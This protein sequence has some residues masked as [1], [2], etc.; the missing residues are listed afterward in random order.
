MTNTS[1]A[2]TVVKKP[3][4]SWFQFSLRTFL[5]AT[6]IIGGLFTKAS[7]EITNARRKTAAFNRLSSDFFVIQSNSDEGSRRWATALIPKSEWESWFPLGNWEHLSSISF[8]PENFRP[9]PERIERA[10]DVFRSLDAFQSCEEVKM[11]A[12]FGKLTTLYGEDLECFR[13]WRTIKRLK[14]DRCMPTPTALRLLSHSTSLMDVEINGAEIEREALAEFLSKSNLEAFSLQY[15]TL[16]GDT[17]LEI[18]PSL[19]TMDVRYS[20][21]SCDEVS[22]W[23]AQGELE[24][25]TYGPPKAPATRTWN[26]ATLKHR[27]C[28]PSWAS[29]FEL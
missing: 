22:D 1:T 13:G 20:G 2:A 15:A 8:V 27:T 19:R 26:S 7:M 25:L 17:P 10:R 24:T 12:S 28:L 6:A 5:I 14:L 11:R 9:T 23:L 29:A 16:A 4:R 18:G 21:I 3:K